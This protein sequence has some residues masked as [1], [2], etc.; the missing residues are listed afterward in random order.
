MVPEAL[1]FL[2]A[3]PSRLAKHVRMPAQ[4]LFRDH[5]HHVAEV[6]G[7]LLLRHASVENDLEQEIAQFLAQAGEVFTCDRV[8]NFI[9]LF[10]RIGGD[11]REIL[12]QVPGAAGPG[13][14]QRRHDGEEGGDVA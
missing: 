6:E 13:R 2:G 8:G 5:M 3:Q 11:G 10:E 1:D 9:G 12:L 4:E 14:A 7:A